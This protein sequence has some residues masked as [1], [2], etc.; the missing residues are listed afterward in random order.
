[1]QEELSES[2]ITKCILFSVKFDLIVASSVCSFL[3]GYEK[4]LALLKSLLVPGGSFIQWDWQATEGNS[5]FG[6]NRER[7]LSAYDKVG[8]K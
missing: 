4:T 8:L 2:L 7:I 5:D 3:P 6:L 1:M